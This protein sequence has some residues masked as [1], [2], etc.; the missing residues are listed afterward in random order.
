AKLNISYCSIT[1][2]ISGRAGL[3]MVDAGNMVRAA[4]ANGL[5]VIT[6]VQPISVLFSL[7]E[8]NLPSVVGRMRSGAPLEVEAMSRDGATKLATGKLLTIDNEI[9]QTTGTFKL[10][11]TFDNPDR[12]LWPNQFVNAR[13]L[14]NVKKN[15][16]IIPSAAV[17]TG[18][19][20][21]FVYVVK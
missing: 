17:Q 16:T 5:L 18:D 10:K 19:K 11:A 4:D 8:D 14:L 13:L 7:P 12:T 21:P 1:A 6:Q 20:G 2:P 3:R 15:A 9:D